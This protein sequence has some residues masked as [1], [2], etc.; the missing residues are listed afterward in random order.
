MKK[1]I[2][3]L[4]FTGIL[5]SDTFSVGKKIFNEKCKSCHTIGEGKRV[6]GDL[7]DI[8]KKRDIEWL[9]KFIKKPSDLFGKDK[10]A[11]SLLKEYKIKMPDLGLTDEE[12]EYV[13]LYIQKMSEEKKEEK[14]QETKKTQIKTEFDREKYERGKALFA[15]EIM[16]KNKGTPCIA[17]HDV[18]G[19]FSFGG[20]KLGP[21]LTEAIENY[22]EEGLALSLSD[23]PFPTMEPVYKNK[24]LEEEEIEDIVYFLKNLKK[25]KKENN[26]FVFAL[27][28]SIFLFFIPLLIWRKK[29]QGVRKNLLKGGE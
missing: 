24:P 2:L 11:D 26:F 18:K 4:F 22:G 21:D 13:I 29:V 20:G 1:L 15:G 28:G 12:V 6:G 9:K 25:E 10:I 14:P 16:F 23:I 27:I 3:L 5:L 17:C 7:K 8:H 19:V